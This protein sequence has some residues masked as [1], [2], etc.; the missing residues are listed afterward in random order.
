MSFHD[1]AS[2]EIGESKFVNTNEIARSPGMIKPGNDII[3]GF[4]VIPLDS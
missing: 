1:E 4:E 3:R 2:A